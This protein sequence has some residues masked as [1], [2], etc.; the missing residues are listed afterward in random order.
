[1]LKLRLLRTAM[2]VET[3]LRARARKDPRR[4]KVV[5]EAIGQAESSA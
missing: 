2:Y 3:K 4:Q 1:M 5:P